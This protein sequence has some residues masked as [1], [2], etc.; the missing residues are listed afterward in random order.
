MVIIWSRLR[1]LSWRALRCGI[2]I[3]SVHANSFRNSTSAFRITNCTR[4]RSTVSIETHIDQAGRQ[5]G[6][7][8]SGTTRSQLVPVEAELN[9]K[10]GS[11]RKGDDADGG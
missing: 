4:A 11:K 9:D 7:R 8:P 1:S 10:Q 3:R 6:R 2:T 5:P